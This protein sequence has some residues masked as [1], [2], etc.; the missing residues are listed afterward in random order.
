VDQKR[1]VVD[2]PESLTGVRRHMMP[3]KRLALT[4]FVSKIPRGARE[5]TLKTALKIQHG[6][7]AVEAG[8][9]GLCCV[10]CCFIA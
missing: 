2:G 8:C 1:V 3:V 6:G 4:D 10:T 5:K 7:G 9:S